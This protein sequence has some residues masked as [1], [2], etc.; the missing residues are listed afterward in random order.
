MTTDS[1]AYASNAETAYIAD[2]SDRDVNRAIDERIVPE[3]FVQLNNERRL[4]HLAAA[5]I[6][7]Y[8][9]TETMFTANMRKR[10]LNAIADQV[11]SYKNV[12]T[13]RELRTLITRPETKSL[14]HFSTHEAGSAV[15][16]DFSKFLSAV[17]MRSE[18]VERALQAVSSND[19][20][21]AGLP[22]FRGTRVRIDSVLASV[23]NGI[24]LSRLQA[25]YPFLS[26]EL[27]ESARIYS[28]VRPRRGRPPRLGEANPGWILKSTTVVH[29][30]SK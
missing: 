1:Q 6:A 16:V 26:H 13:E 10:V 25:S 23:D 9:K 5:F 7:F 30:A 20:V 29:P 15:S 2:V 28:L 24:E 18:Q 14:F 19:D 22:V 8:C 3:A 4:S 12:P 17:L 21:M 27:I 11:K